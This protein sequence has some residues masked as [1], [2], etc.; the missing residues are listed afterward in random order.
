M[1][2][3][4]KGGG[5]TDDEIHVACKN[6]G[7]DM[8]CGSCAEQFYC[9]S[10]R[11]EHTCAK[12]APA[13][14]S[15]AAALDMETASLPPTMSMDGEVALDSPPFTP[16]ELNDFAARGFERTFQTK[17]AT[18]DVEAVERLC[19]AATPGPW[20]VIPS[21]SI[22]DFFEVCRED[23]PQ[24]PAL[25]GDGLE[26][27]EADFIAASRTLVPTLLTEV[28]RLREEVTLI[29]AS[30]DNLVTMTQRALR[31]TIVR[32]ETAEKRVSNYETAYQSQIDQRV[33]AEK[34]AEEAEASVRAMAA[35]SSACRDRD[36]HTHRGL[37]WAHAVAN[38]LDE[39][40]AA[41]RRL[42][43]GE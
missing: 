12:H 9:G 8:T 40:I 43:K 34:R 1:T 16:P 35:A 2:A 28:K 42:A 29:E 31:E 5:L 37:A 14:P 21:R 19:D 4:T 6:I 20:L 27:G 39:A 7:H 26:Q 33:E 18:L 11:F 23:L 25:V 41:A 15:P 30:R 3:P 10:S 17:A 13:P 22:P 38:G 36:R 24:P 32:A